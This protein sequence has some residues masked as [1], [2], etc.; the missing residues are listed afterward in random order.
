MC[1]CVCEREKN[2][3]KKKGGCDEKSKSNLIKKSLPLTVNIF[4]IGLLQRK[5]SVT[6]NLLLSAL[7]FISIRI[8]PAVLSFCVFVAY[9]HAMRTMHENIV[10]DNTA[11]WATSVVN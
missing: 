7:I 8:S 9:Q 11:T 1:G 2:K 10:F 3:N 5:T 4:H 6:L